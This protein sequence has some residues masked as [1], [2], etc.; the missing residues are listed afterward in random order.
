MET[1]E[2]RPIAGWEDRYEVSSLGNVRRISPGRGA[3]VGKVL[4]TRLF[5]SKGS[6]YPAVNLYRP[7]YSKGYYVHIL[8]AR[9]FLGPTPIGKEINHKDL[10]KTNPRLD[11]LEFLTHREN[12]DHA[13]QGG[14][15]HKGENHWNSKIT[16]EDV[17]AI[18]RLSAEGMSYKDISDKY[19]LSIEAIGRITLGKSWKH[20]K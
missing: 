18:R 15:I 17:R 1:E 6:K 13:S 19:P 3:T 5:G 12:A 9:A 20:V 10:V 8:V 16:E 7:G 14:V 4:T 11:N 2:W